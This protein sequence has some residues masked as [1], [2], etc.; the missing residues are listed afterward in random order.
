MNTI[1]SAFKSRIFLSL[2][3]VL[4]FFIGITPARAVTIDSYFGWNYVEGPVPEAHLV[5]FSYAGGS[6]F[7]TQALPSF[8]SINGM[9]D[10][11]GLSATPTFTTGGDGETT[12]TISAALGL[13]WGATALPVF[14]ILIT[15]FDFLA[16]GTG[17]SPFTASF[18]TSLST[19]YQ[20]GLIPFGSNDELSSL[21]FAPQGD[22]YDNLA[23]I[24]GNPL[25]GAIITKVPVGFENF[26]GQEMLVS[27]AAATVPLPAAIWLMASGLLG[28][29]LVRRRRV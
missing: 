12:R 14:D 5:D 2:G 15:D 24:S 10:G 21:L 26:L 18:G 1:T 13:D 3:T 9:P 16:P 11:A 6:G 28:L 8:G 19:A 22:I 25:R 27:F 29:I 23:G 7:F 4:V 20:V 17:P